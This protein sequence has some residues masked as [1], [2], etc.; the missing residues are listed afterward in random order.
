MCS[1]IRNL[2]I[3]S[4]E[5]GV[6]KFKASRIPYLADDGPRNT[7]ELPPAPPDWLR[8][9]QD[10]VCG[11]ESDQICT[12]RQQR[13]ELLSLVKLDSVCSGPFLMAT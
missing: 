13:C 11:A 2:H 8:R 12:F 10:M 9:Q 5:Y 3:D 4:A 7:A 1:Y 6:L